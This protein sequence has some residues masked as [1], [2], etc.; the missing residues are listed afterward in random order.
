MNIWYPLFGWKFWKN[1]INT[2]SSLKWFFSVITKLFKIMIISV[3]YVS[4][5]VDVAAYVS[6]SPSLLS[7]E[8]VGI[9]E[10]DAV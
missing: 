10:L 6:S 3:M 8:V 9:S 7:V 4:Q 2:Y 5:K 1:L